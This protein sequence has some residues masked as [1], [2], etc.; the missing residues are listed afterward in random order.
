MKLFILIV[1]VLTVLCGYS[2][3]K[4]ANS[5]HEKSQAQL[6]EVLKDIER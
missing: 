4:A 6:N 3:L 1:L 5:I 2:L